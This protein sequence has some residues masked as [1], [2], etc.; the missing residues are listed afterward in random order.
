MDQCITTAD[1]LHYSI[2]VLQ[3][4]QRPTWCGKH[5]VCCACLL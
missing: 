4:G 2:K 3:V 5:P 1:A